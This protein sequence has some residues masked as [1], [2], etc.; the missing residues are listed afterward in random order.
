MD[1]DEGP[2]TPLGRLQAINAFARAR[3]GYKGIEGKSAEAVVLETLDRLLKEQA[4]GVSY[5][6]SA[7][8]R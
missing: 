1:D 3:L 4:A 7:S 6:F 5:A 2:G 8:L